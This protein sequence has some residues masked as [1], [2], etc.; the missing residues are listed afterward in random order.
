VTG[1][2]KA[3]NARGHGVLDAP[4]IQNSWDRF[5][6]GLDGSAW[7]LLRMHQTPQPRCRQPPPASCWE[8]PCGRLL[9]ARPT[10]GRTPTGIAPAVGR[11][12]LP[13]RSMGQLQG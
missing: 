6:A 3:T 5:K 7:H 8:D 4:T 1:S 9:A 13:E 11:A 2:D 10:Y 12:G